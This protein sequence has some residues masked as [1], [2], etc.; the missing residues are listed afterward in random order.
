MDP[1]KAVGQNE[2]SF[3]KGTHVVPSNTVLDRGSGHPREGEIWGSEPPVRSDVAYSK[4]TVIAF[5]LNCD[6]A[7]QI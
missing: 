2:M 1:P 7:K 3:D 6:S 5:N 4:I